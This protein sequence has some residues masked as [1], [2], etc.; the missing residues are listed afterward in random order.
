MKKW[1]LVFLL[2]KDQTREARERPSELRGPG[3]KY[4][5]NIITING[6]AVT[7]V[8]IIAATNNM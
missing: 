8:V 1:S 5:S 3:A 4:L 2:W 7:T 6:V